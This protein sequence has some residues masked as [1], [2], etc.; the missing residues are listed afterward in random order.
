VASAPPSVRHGPPQWSSDSRRLAYLAE[1]FVEIV[2][3][4]R[5]TSERLTLPGREGRPSAWKW[6]LSWSPDGRSFAYTDAADE[7]DQ[8]TQMWV[9]RRE[10]G[11]GFPVAASPETFNASPSW[12]SDGRSLFFVSDRGGSTDLLRQPLAPDGTPMGRP[13]QLTTGVEM[14][15]AR[16]SADTSR[17]AYSKGRQK[18]N[19]LRV[20]IL[21]GRLATWLDTRQ[22][23]DAP[24]Y[25]HHVYLSPDQS[26]LAF[27]LRR[28]AGT[29]IFTMPAEGG[30]AERLLMDP[31]EQ[32]WARWSP[33]GGKIAFH[34]EGEIWVAPLRVGQPVRLTETEAPDFC[35]A[36][37]PD[38]LEIA[39][40]SARSGNWD[41]WA[42]P[43]TGGE[44]RQITTDPSRDWGLTWSPD[45]REIAFH[46]NRSGNADVWVI[47]SE[48]GEARQLT[49]DPA[50]DSWPFWSPDGRWIVFRSD[51]ARTISGTGAPSQPGLWRVPAGGGAAELVVESVRESFLPSLAWSTRGDQVYFAARLGD[52]GNLY[53]KTFGSTDERRLTDF[54]GRPGHL[55]AIHDADGEFLYFTWNEDDGDVWVMAVDEEKSSKVAR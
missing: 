42:L 21:E 16:F 6:H 8:Q 1:G 41:V 34:S 55:G 48:G 9:V 46:S 43:A 20:P 33:D 54:A 45:G 13:Q 53:E 2:S 22:L 36:W 4:E 17:L 31:M 49:K 40:L 27:S 37:S 24:G 28:Q 38:G 26:R 50:T 14:L 52:R 10:D 15:F 19:I 3:L 32:I 5:G 29:H 12:A 47:P 25:P 35:P 30:N 7:F 51:R 23:T 44:P 18:R 39:F 11:Q